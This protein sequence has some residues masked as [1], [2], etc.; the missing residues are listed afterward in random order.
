MDE[1]QKLITTVDEQ[2]EA[3]HSPHTVALVKPKSFRPQP[4]YTPI[5]PSTGTQQTQQIQR[6]KHKTPTYKQNASGNSYDPHQTFHLKPI[7]LNT[8]GT[9]KTP[10]L[11]DLL[12]SSWVIHRPEIGHTQL[13]TSTWSFAG[14]I[15]WTPPTQ[16]RANTCTTHNNPDSWRF[17]GRIAGPRPIQ[18]GQT[19]TEKP[20]SLL[21]GQDEV[22]LKSQPAHQ[23]NTVT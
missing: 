22:R 10:T 2:Q 21:A 16:D 18:D 4:S 3:Q 20:H 19:N 8:T 7:M 23:A 6:T 17:A 15:G 12:A 11:G 5:I 1:Q 14:R 13:I 9:T